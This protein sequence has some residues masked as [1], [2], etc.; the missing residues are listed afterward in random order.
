AFGGLDPVY[1]EEGGL[2][3][4]TLTPNYADMIEWLRG[5]YAAGSLPKEFAA[6]KITQA[7]ELY[8]TGRAVSYVRNVWRDYQF[9]Q[10]IKKVQPEAEV[11]TLPPMKGPGGYSVHLSPPTFGAMYISRKVP[12]E[13]VKRILDYME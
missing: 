11:I 5:L 2:I 9:E 3:K 8:K 10:E 1:N 13:K 6:I 4:E 7:E 12:E